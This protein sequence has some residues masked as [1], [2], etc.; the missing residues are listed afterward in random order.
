MDGLIHDPSFNILYP[1]QGSRVRQIAS[2]LS[3]VPSGYTGNNIR[4]LI[5]FVPQILSDPE[6]TEVDGL[7][8][9]KSATKSFRTRK[10]RKWMVCCLEKVPRRQRTR[11]PRLVPTLLGRFAFCDDENIRYSDDL[12]FATT[13]THQEPM[14]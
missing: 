11:Y 4:R 14:L 2:N 9:G 10:R 6:T 7:L 3:S 1:I 5:Y 13:K 12:H 8:F